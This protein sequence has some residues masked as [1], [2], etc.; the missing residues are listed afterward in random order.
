MVDNSFHTRRSNLSLDPYRCYHQPNVEF[1]LK[2]GRILAGLPGVSVAKSMECG[3]PQTR[4]KR[5]A[6]LE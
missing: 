4:E 1:R 2:G 5:D 6:T 3:V